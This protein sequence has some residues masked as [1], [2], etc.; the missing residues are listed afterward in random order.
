MLNFVFDVMSNVKLNRHRRYSLT[1]CFSGHLK[2]IKLRTRVNNVVRYVSNCFISQ[3][4]PLHLNITN[5][6]N[7]ILFGGSKLINYYYEKHRV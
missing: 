7:V 2:L 4:I 6:S 5:K 3:K 1:V